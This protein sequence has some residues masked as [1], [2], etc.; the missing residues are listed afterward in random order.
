MTFHASPVTQYWV[1]IVVHITPGWVSKCFEL[2]KQNDFEL[3]AIDFQ[4]VFRRRLR[5]VLHHSQKHT[6]H[7]GIIT[8]GHIWKSLKAKTRTLPSNS[9]LVDS[10]KET[11][12]TSHSWFQCIEHPG[13]SG[14]WWNASRSACKVLHGPSTCLANS[15]PSQCEHPG[16]LRSSASGAKAVPL[17]GPA[18][19]VQLRD[20]RLSQAALITTCKP[21]AFQI[22]SCM[23]PL[24]V[25]QKE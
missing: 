4:P 13:I 21:G 9:S 14:T 22:F 6:A 12:K 18:C 23:E 24:L 5:L 1:S 16:P 3:P 25:D 11:K 7:T 2:Y 8:W 15:P 17:R 19:S 20:S 10:N